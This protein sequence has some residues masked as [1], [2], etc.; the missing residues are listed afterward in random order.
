MRL[1]FKY[2]FAAML[3]LSCALRVTAG[4]LEDAEAAY[5][6]GD[7]AK[8]LRLIRP[9]A[10]KGDPIAQNNLGV[11]YG[12][13]RDVRQDYV[14]A[15]KWYRRS[16]EGGYGIAQYNLGLRYQ[17]GQGVAQDYTE[18][19]K[20]YLRAADQGLAD[21]QATL[22]MIYREGIGVRQ[23]RFR[24]YVWYTLSARD[25]D[26]I[27]RVIRDHLAEEL[28]P[29]RRAEAERLVRDWKPYSCSTL[30]QVSDFPVPNGPFPVP[31]GPLAERH[32]AQKDVDDK[33][34][35]LSA[36]QKKR[37]LEKSTSMAEEALRRAKDDKAEQTTY[38]H[39][40]QFLSPMVGWA[41]DWHGLLH[42]TSDGG[43]T[44]KEK[45]LPL[46]GGT[47]GWLSKRF[48]VPAPEE[49][50]FR[51][52]HFADDRFGLIVGGT[53]IL[54][55][56]DGGDTWQPVP[57][58]PS[59]MQ[60]TAV[61]CSTGHTCWVGAGL[62]IYRRSDSKSAW[63][64]QNIPATS[65]LTAIQFI[66]ESTGRCPRSVAS[67]PGLRACPVGWALS[68]GELIGTTDGGDHWITLFHDDRKR[69]WGFQ[70]LDENLG[71]M[72]GANGLIMHTEDGGKTWM[73]QWISLPTDAPRK[74]IRLHDVKFADLERG[75]T[76][77]LHGMIFATTDGGQCWRLQRYEGVPAN[78]LTIYSLAI[79]D[80]PTIWAA[81]NAGN[82]FASI[83]G[84]AV[85]FPVHGIAVPIM[86]ALKRAIE[87]PAN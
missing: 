69:L 63:S 32:A 54:Q 61:Y 2:V 21:A 35:A 65:P 76:A 73:D 15:V 68:R 17:N 13:G 50:P 72:V 22:G 39:A 33:L 1:T 24:A 9:L 34:R 19:L 56:E 51:T 55:S 31:N 62:S 82:I 86:D 43:L 40:I 27:T 78:F 75:W 53:G 38:L 37:L 83:D 87:A 6:K 28:S 60:P 36:D 12:E 77:G 59:K 48:N 71:W 30:S 57:L 42:G 67:R 84:G 23:D 18:A 85:W 41:L 81:G 47:I 66:D 7:Y 4:P 11:L 44:W 26:L 20:W 29:D 10:E 49:A 58:P 8:A 52:M 3:V 70:F 45:R 25:G 5:S 79:T 74:E 64:R 14:E 16:A 80:G 46:G